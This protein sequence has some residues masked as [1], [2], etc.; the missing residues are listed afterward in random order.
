MLCRMSF[1]F[2]VAALALSGADDPWEKVR[3]LK[4]GQ[5]LRIVRRDARQP[6]LAKMDEASAE[7]LVVV[8]GDR[9]TSIPKDQIDRVDARPVQRGSRVTRES[10]TSTTYSDGVKGPATQ[11][12]NH[13]GPAT[14]SSSGISVGGK[15]DFELVYRR[16]VGAPPPNRSK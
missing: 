12:N 11:M 9:Q 2:L 15:P 14:S 13:P 7:A 8:I 10:K 4:S 3:A 16:S 6:V 1:L 5:E